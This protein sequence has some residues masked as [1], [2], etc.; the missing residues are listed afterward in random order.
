[1]AA[2][3]IIDSL[4][5]EKR[6]KVLDMLLRGESLREIA[7]IAGVSH[8]AVQGYKRK[9][10]MPAIRTAQKVQSLQEVSDD[11]GKV[12]TEQSRLTRAIVGASPF[13]DR[14]EQLWGRTDRALSQAEQDKELSVMAPLLNQAHKNV[15]LLGRV[16]GELEVS[17]PMVAIQ[18]VCP[19]TENR[20]SA[21][22]AQTIDISLSR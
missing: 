2:K 13:R 5:K 12:V 9:V 4:P 17:T 20:P 16:T 14:L 3:S 21:A 19:V 18:I 8:V 6:Q 15:E 11:P 7:K 10:V 1:M 22:A